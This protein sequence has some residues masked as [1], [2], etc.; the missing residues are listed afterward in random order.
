MIKP[1]EAIATKLANAAGKP[2]WE[3]EEAQLLD[4]HGAITHNGSA[5]EFG[6]ADGQQRGFE[7]YGAAAVRGREFRHLPLELVHQ[8]GVGLAIVRLRERLARCRGGSGAQSGRMR[9]WQK[10][11]YSGGNQ[12]RKHAAPT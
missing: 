10:L 12:E 6:L 5:L 1:H 4:P 3:L 9:G 11:P 2:P 8:V 7:G